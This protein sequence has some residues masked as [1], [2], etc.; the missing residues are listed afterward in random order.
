[1]IGLKEIIGIFTMSLADRRI[2][3]MAPPILEVS[4]MTRINMSAIVCKR[5][6]VVKMARHYGVMQ[7]Q[8]WKK[9]FFV[10]PDVWGIRIGRGKTHKLQQFE[11]ATKLR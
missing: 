9:L 10:N 7:I 8:S 1:M 6:G 11:I 4:D 3:V 5:C 2:M